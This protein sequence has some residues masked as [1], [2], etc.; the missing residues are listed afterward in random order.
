MF[1]ENKS[2]SH[3]RQMDMKPR[4]IKIPLAYLQLEAVNAIF[5]KF[6]KNRVLSLKTNEQRYQ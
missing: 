5:C 3:T 1:P 4:F 2:S 6:Q